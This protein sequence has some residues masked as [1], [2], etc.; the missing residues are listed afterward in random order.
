MIPFWK[1]RLFE[2]RC[3]FLYKALNIEIRACAWRWTHDGGSNTHPSRVHPWQRPSSQW[4]EAGQT[5]SIKFVQFRPSGDINALSSDGR[6]RNDA[7]IVAP[8]MLSFRFICNTEQYSS[9]AVRLPQPS[10]NEYMLTTADGC[11][12]KT[13]ITQGMLLRSLSDAWRHGSTIIVVNRWVE[14]LRWQL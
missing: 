5:N 13:T 7:R 11:K 14:K 9:A 4:S 6:S 3:I 2:N 10:I 12:N 8:S 1:H